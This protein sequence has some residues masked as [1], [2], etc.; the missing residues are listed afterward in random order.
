MKTKK[1]E[2][3]KP[4]YYAI[5]PAEVRYSKK[6]GSTAKLLYAEI[7][8]LANKEGYCWANNKYFSKLFDV[9]VTHISLLI[10]DLQENKFIIMEIDKK[11]GNARKIYINTYMEKSEEVLGKIVIGIRKNRKY[12]IKSNNKKN[13]NNIKNI[14]DKQE[15]CLSS[16]EIKELLKK[17]K[18][19][20][21]RDEAR[22]L[23][24]FL[25][26]KLDTKIVNWGKQIKA[27]GL[28]DKAGYTEI[29]IKKTIIYMADN[30]DFFADRGFN[31]MT[32]ANQISRYK[33][34][35]GR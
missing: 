33:A 8:S 16:E 31:L 3:V 21:I 25:E 14:I 32:V 28:M 1:T 19:L 23:V 10:S 24:R 20:K 11:R 26:E 22:R 18:G 17:K 13:K 15:V 6:I 7:S 29:Q 27:V 5:I 35:A 9:G 30:D 12:N 4:S 34:K 2:E